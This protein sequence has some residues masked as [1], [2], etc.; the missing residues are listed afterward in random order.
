MCAIRNTEHA[1]RNR[2]IPM[3]DLDVRIVTL[4]PMRVASAH[5][6]SA[7]PEGEAWDK[8][9]AWAKPKGLLED[10]TAHRI[11][12]FNNPN[13]SPGTP[14]YGYEFWIQRGRARSRSRTLRG[15]CTPSPAATACPGSARTG[16][17]WRPGARRAPTHTARTNGSK[18][19][20]RLR[21]AR[22]SP[23]RNWCW[24]CTCRSQS[25]A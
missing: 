8:L 6:Y 20:S 3:S 2:R 23:S 12:G 16:S 10:A 9:I 17:S 13:P 24:I 25:S 15:G 14:N 5:A 22:R 19:T 4:E 1:T 11:F 18:S 21:R 7:S